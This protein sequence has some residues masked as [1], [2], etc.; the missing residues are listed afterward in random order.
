MLWSLSWNVKYTEVQWWEADTRS[1]NQIHYL[2]TEL[3]INCPFLN[4]RLFLQEQNQWNLVSCWFLFNV[5]APPRPACYAFS[6]HPVIPLVSRFSSPSHPLI[7]QAPSLTCCLGRAAWAAGQYMC[8]FGQAAAAGE[9]LTSC[10]SLS[11][12]IKACCQ[13][14]VNSLEIRISPA[15]NLSIKCGWGW[16]AG[17]KYT[18]GVLQAFADAFFFPQVTGIILK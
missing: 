12:G 17:S 9:Q 18:Q 4:N 15:S 2:S 14:S 6:R 11:G 10:F 16:A 8:A 1:S 5:P 3:S 13:F 7:S